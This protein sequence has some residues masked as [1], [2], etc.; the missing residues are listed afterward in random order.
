MDSGP[1]SVPGVTWNSRRK[2]AKAAMYGFLW[3]SVVVFF[4]GLWPWPKETRDFMYDVYQTFT[5]ACVGVIFGYMGTTTLPFIGR[6][7]QK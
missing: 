6:G 7:W 5:M 3:A 4:I 2:M 1:P